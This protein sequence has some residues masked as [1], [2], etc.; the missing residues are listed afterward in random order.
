MLHIHRIRI[1][2]DINLRNNI[3]QKNL[4]NLAALYQVIE[5]AGNKADLGQQLLDYLGQ[6]LVDR[7]VVDRG[8]VEGEADVEA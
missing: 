8:Q 4:L 6:G 2:S 1:S 3:E 5:Q 7:V